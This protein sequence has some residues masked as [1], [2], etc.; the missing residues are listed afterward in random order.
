[1]TSVERTIPIRATRETVARFFTETPQF[2]AWWGRGSQVDPR[3]GGALRI[4]FPNGVVVR[5]EVLESAPPERFVF[6]YGYEDPGKPIPVGGSR[7]EITLQLAT[8]ATRLHL[9][10]ELP[11]AAARDPHVPGWWYQ[12]A[13]LA[14]HAADLQNADL[15]ARIDGWFAAWNGVGD[16]DVTDDVTFNDPYACLAGRQEL[17]T[18]VSSVRAHL[19]L[20]LARDG[21]PRHCQGR[22]LCDWAATAA[23]G[24]VKARGTNLFDLAPDGRIRGVIGFWGNTR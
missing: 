13:L 16:F 6:T 18:H 23:D 22:V 19:P 4:V 1:M 3:P 17:L 11:D 12:L 21:E 10:H 2:A 8:G 9:R 24:A 14:N 5:G 7:V 15:A 20:S